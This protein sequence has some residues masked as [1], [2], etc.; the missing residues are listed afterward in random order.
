MNIFM[1]Q[2]LIISMNIKALKLFVNTKL[3]TITYIYSKLF[4][5]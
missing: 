5:C 4:S 2:Y 1:T 3:F